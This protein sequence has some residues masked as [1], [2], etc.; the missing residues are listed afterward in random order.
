M[1]ILKQNID[2][3]NI[4][5]NTKNYDL[6]TKWYDVVRCKLGDQVFGLFG[7]EPQANFNASRDYLMPLPADEL[8]RNP[9]LEPNNPGY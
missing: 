8:Q 5:V 9:N 1:L 7:L 4:A 2:L 6:L 3:E